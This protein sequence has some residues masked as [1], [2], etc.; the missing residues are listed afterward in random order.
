M[1]PDG[2]GVLR[3]LRSA[4]STSDTESSIFVP[5]LLTQLQ[6]AISSVMAFLERCPGRQLSLPLTAYTTIS[7]RLMRCAAAELVIAN[8]MVDHIFTDIY[9]PGGIDRQKAVS[10]TLE[11]LVTK[12]PRRESLVR[13]QLLEEYDLDTE[14]ISNVHQAAFKEVCDVLDDLLPADSLRNKFH[15][16]LSALLGEALELWQPLRKSKSRVSAHLS[17][18]TKIL[19]RDEDAYPDYDGL[20]SQRTVTPGNPAFAGSEPVI[21]LFPL[22]CTSK[23][24]VCSPTALWSDQGAFI[25]AKNEA[26]EHKLGMTGSVSAIDPVRPSAARRKMSTGGRMPTSPI[27]SQPPDLALNAPSDVSSSRPIQNRGSENGI[28]STGRSR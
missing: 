14:I 23:E 25:E 12:N 15:S 24:V 18:R 5:I 9:I 28:K 6:K 3:T 2:N 4:T 26:A 10:A 1:P 8:A 20:R 11:L 17:M 13:C 21:L 27:S 16:K 19:K 22:I 7:A